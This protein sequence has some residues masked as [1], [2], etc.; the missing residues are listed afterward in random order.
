[1]NDTDFSITIDTALHL[2]QEDSLSSYRDQFLIPLKQDGTSCAYFTGNSLGLQPVDTRDHVLEV[3]ESWKD[4][5]VEGHSKGA[6]PWMTYHKPLE[7]SLATI[8]GAKAEEVTLMNTLTVNLHLMMVS[9][10]RPTPKRFK[11]L[12]EAN[13]FPS[14]TYAVQSQVLLHGYDPKEAIVVIE[15]LPGS[16]IITDEA[17]ANVLQEQGNQIALVL[18]GGVNYYTGQ[19]FD[20][21]SITDLAHAKGCQVGFDLAHAAGNLLL[22]LHNWDVDFAIWCTYKYLNGGP[23]NLSGCFIHTRHHVNQHLPRLQGWW[24]N[25][26]ATR[27]DMTNRFDPAPGAEAWQLS[28]PPILALSSLKASLDLFDEVGMRQLRQKSVKLTAYLSYLISHRLSDKVEIITPSTPNQRGAQLSLRLKN[29]GKAIHDALISSGIICDW[30]EPD[31]IRVAPVPF[32]N[33]YL[34]VFHF[35]DAIAKE[36]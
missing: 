31:A 29:D 28:N 33:A 8:V 20:M 19:A 23:G 13:A 5:G 15:P 36:Y 27:F 9:F 22:D 6:L 24:G 35:V 18:L 17:I 3:L 25:H 7:A 34:D 11:V 1:M 4:L 2:D 14:D 30:R 32:Y 10:Y 16:D 21:G 12:M 26:L